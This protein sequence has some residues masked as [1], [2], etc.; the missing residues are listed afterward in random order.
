MTRSIISIGLARGLRADDPRARSAWS[1]PTTS[2]SSVVA[3]PSIRLGETRTPPFAIVLTAAAICTPLTESDWPNAM[4][5]CIW[6]VQVLPAGSRPEVSPRT[7][8]SVRLAEPEAAAGSRG[9]G[10]A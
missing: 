4:R 6:W 7:P 3:E 2:P 8:M 1:V 5:S 9:A 10:P